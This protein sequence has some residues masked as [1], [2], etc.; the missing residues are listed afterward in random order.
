MY[1]L[2]LGGQLYGQMPVSGIGVLKEY[3]EV[4]SEESL[5]QS[6]RVLLNGG[7]R[8]VCLIYLIE[9]KTASKATLNY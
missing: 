5:R 9:G 1:N 6:H 8:R 2:L 7:Q 4:G 3:V